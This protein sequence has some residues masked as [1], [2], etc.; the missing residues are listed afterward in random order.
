M[1]SLFILIYIFQD[2]NDVSSLLLVP[3]ADAVVQIELTHSSPYDFGMDL[4]NQGRRSEALEL[5]NHLIKGLEGDAKLHCVL[6]KAWC[7]WSNID[8]GKALQEADYIVRK[9]S[10]PLLLARAHS[11]IGNIHAWWNA[12]DKAIEHFDR[13][14]KY[15]DAIKKDGGKFNCLLGKASVA[16]NRKD[17]DNAFVLIDLAKKLS[18]KS[19]SKLDCKISDIYADIEFNEFRFEKC[20]LI[21][22]KSLREYEGR[23]SIM[24]M[25]HEARIGLCYALIGEYDLSFEYAQRVDSKIN[26]NPSAFVECYNNLTWLFHNRCRGYD[27][28][29]IKSRIVAWCKLNDHANQIKG[30]LDFIETETCPDGLK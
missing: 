21:S 4:L 18:P 1:L 29:E 5:F 2:A 19:K 24:T 9:T 12:P 7:Y 14:F 3:P 25:F 23:S 11:L 16:I 26:A 6:G 27:Y 22:E 8:A 10:E 30:V 20:I 17:Y 28:A 15:Y 13:S